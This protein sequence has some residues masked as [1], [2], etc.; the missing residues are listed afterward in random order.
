MLLFSSLFKKE[1]YPFKSVCNGNIKPAIFMGAVLIASSCSIKDKFEWLFKRSEYG[2]PLAHFTAKHGAYFPNFIKTFFPSANLYERDFPSLLEAKNDIRL[3]QVKKLN[4]SNKNIQNE[5][6]LSWS[7]DGA[8]LSFEATTNSE[9]RI[10]VKNLI[11]DYSEELMVL[12]KKRDNFLD[13]LINQS[14][15][16]YNAGLSW[17]RDSTRYAFMSNGGVGEYNI[18][19]GAIGFKEKPVIKSRSKDGYATWNPRKNEIAFVSARTGNGD[20]YLLNMDTN[21]LNR[22]SS[23]RNIDIFPEWFPSGNSIVFSSGTSNNHNIM[24]V[25]RDKNNK[26]W[27]KPTHLTNWKYDTLRPIISPNGHY[28]AFYANTGLNNNLTPTWNIHVIPYIE[29]KIYSEQELKRT[30]I[31]KNVVVDI[32]TGPAWTPDSRK[33]FFV[34]QDINKFNP[35]YAYDLYTGRSYT[36]KTNTRMNRDILMSKLGILSFR[37]QVGSWDR[38]FVALTNQGLQLQKSE[39]SKFKIHYLYQ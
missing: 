21:K 17:S 18:Y 26:K 34:K 20:I 23:S 39:K 24:L 29:G 25:R 37:A 19:I 9:K 32:N 5:A 38:V 14:I 6:N 11:G 15:H 4:L 16:S 10:L 8:Y 7:C 36:I 35:I 33:L 3:I 13:G 2:V 12:P 28:I 31:A 1:T 22:L 30:I 27:L